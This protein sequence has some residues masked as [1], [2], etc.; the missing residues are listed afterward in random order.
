MDKLEIL[1]SPKPYACGYE[2][3]PHDKQLHAKDLCFK[4]NN[5][6]PSDS[7]GR[8]EILK[9]LFGTCSDLTFIGEDFH[10]DYG[11]NIHTHGLAVINYNCVILDTSPVHIGDGAFIGPNTCLACSG[12]SLDP[13]QRNK[14]I[15]NSAPITLKDNVWLGANVTVC[16]GVTIGEGSVIGAGSV[17]T[18]DIPSGVIAAGVPCKVKR[19][20]TAEDAIKEEEILF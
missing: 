8:L 3:V 5:T 6:P 15:G 2:N 18:K 7:K 12:H 17:V 19:K 1:K 11:F 13:K 20:I 14:G 4:Y 10:C 16:A 9:Q